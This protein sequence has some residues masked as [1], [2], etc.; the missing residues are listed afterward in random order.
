MIVF[1]FCQCTVLF[2]NS[3][4]NILR[5]I[6]YTNDIQE[7]I[8]DI[9]TIIGKTVE[10][11]FHPSNCP[12][13]NETIFNQNILKKQVE[14]S[15]GLL[16]GDY[17]GIT[18]IGIQNYKLQDCS[19]SSL[20][21]THGFRFNDKYD[22]NVANQEYKEEFCTI[23]SENRIS[24]PKIRI[25][26]EQELEFR[27]LL[28]T[29]RSEELSLFQYQSLNALPIALIICGFTAKSKNYLEIDVHY[30]K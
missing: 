11:C 3:N 5:K 9:K 15:D 27:F 8:L 18:K 7:G 10:K 2:N 28:G 26:S 24:C 21:I 17:F 4:K 23:Y 16:E 1:N 13:L 30:N 6:K 22:F 29:L 20:L 14:Y 19:E 12:G 25:N